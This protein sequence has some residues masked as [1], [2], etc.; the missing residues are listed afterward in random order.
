MSLGPRRILGV[1]GERLWWLHL[2]K[3]VVVLRLVVAFVTNDVLL[4]RDLLV[5]RSIVAVA[6]VNPN[7]GFR[8]AAPMVRVHRGVVVMTVGVARLGVGSPMGGGAIGG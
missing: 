1:F 3:F 8:S 2:G 4:L 7:A 6:D 5:G